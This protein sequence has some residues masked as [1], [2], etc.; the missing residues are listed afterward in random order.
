[1]EILAA[2]MSITS[3]LIMRIRLVCTSWVLRLKCW[4]ESST[5]REAK[6]ERIR[7]NWKWVRDIS[8]GINWARYISAEEQEQAFANG[9]PIRQRGDH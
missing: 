2:Y 5:K 7:R 1:M 6:I 8:Y 3:D 9:V 4:T